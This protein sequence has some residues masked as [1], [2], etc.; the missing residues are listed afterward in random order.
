VT[1]EPATG[2]EE[3]TFEAALERLDHIVGRLERGEVPLEESLALF[4]EGV[5]LA[6]RCQTLLVDADERIRRLVPD[7]EGFVLEPFDAGAAGDDA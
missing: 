7:G 5:K 4:E 3:P 6:R 1:S 2:V